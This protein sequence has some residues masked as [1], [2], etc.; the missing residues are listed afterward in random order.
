M[1]IKGEYEITFL[2]Q[3][4][5]NS[6]TMTTNNN[7]IVTDEGLNLILNILTEKSTDSFG[8]VYIGTNSTE[9]S[10]LDTVST[11]RNPVSLGNNRKL[12]DNVLTYEI[13]TDGS[14]LVGTCEIGIWSKS[15]T[16]LITRDVHDEYDVPTSTII[17]IKY[18]L[19]LSNKTS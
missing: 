1:Q 12:T 18:S 11:F 9:A 8:D 14:I 16:K 6:Y 7:N 15:R 3:N 4:M 13:S 10:P 5:F 2:I 17:K 19:T